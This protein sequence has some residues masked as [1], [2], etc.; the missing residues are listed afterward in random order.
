M[1][2]RELP[3]AI[4]EA[5]DMP[6]DTEVQ[7]TVELAGSTRRDQLLAVMVEIGAQCEANGMTEE[8]L[9]EILNER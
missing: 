9:E 5:I 8:I 6:P 4:R 3:A 2:L 7:V 1:K